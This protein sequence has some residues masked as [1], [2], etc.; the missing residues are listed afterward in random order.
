MKPVDAIEFALRLNNKRMNASK[1]LDMVKDLVNEDS[2]DA[3]HLIATAKS[4]TSRFIV[5]D[6]AI[7][8]QP[9]R[10]ANRVGFFRARLMGVRDALKLTPFIGSSTLGVELALVYAFAVRKADALPLIVNENDGLWPILDELASEF[11]PLKQ[12]LVGGLKEA[13]FMVRA[14]VQTELLLM[15]SVRLTPLEYVQEMR[16]LLTGQS[17]MWQFCLPWSVGELMTRLLGDDVKEVFDPAADSSVLPVLLSLRDVARADAVFMNRFSEF[18]TT[19]QARI[20]GVPFKSFLR[21]VSSIPSTRKYAHCISAPPFGGKISAEGGSRSVFAVA[22]EQVI[23][24]LAPGGQAAIL[25]PESMVFGHSGRAIRERL[26]KEGLLRT[27]I[28]LPASLFL[29]YAGVK[30]SILVLHSAASPGEVVFIDA[31]PYTSLGAKRSMTLDVDRL[32]GH[33]ASRNEELPIVHMDS[34]TLIRDENIDLSVARWLALAV[35]VDGRS[36]SP[37]SI[38][39]LGAL[40]IGELGRI[41]E[42]EDLPYFQVS[43]LASG[44]ADLI[45]TADHGRKDRPASAR[46]A[47]VLDAPALLVARVGGTLKPTLFDPS[48]GP[49]ALG[50]NVLA[51]RVKEELVDPRYLAVELRSGTVQEQVESYARGIAVPSL[52]KAD[53]LRLLIRVPDRPQ[54]VRIVE[55]QLDLGVFLD[56]VKTS[57]EPLGGD[58]EHFTRLLIKNAGSIGPS[59]MGKV[60]ND[61]MTHEIALAVRANASVTDENMRMIRHQ[62]NNRLG[63]LT[64]GIGSIRR[65]ILG[66]MDSGLI[67]QDMPIAPSLLGEE[68]RPPKVTETIEQLLANAGQ[69]SL[70]LDA[71]TRTIQNKGPELQE[72]EL[73]EFF[74][75]HIAPLYAAD[76][77]FDLHIHVVEGT[78]TTVNA[79]PFLLQQVVTNI[80]D[81]AVKHGFSD[82]QRRYNVYVGL[83]DQSVLIANDGAP[84]TISLQEMIIRGS[85]AGENAGTGFGMYMVNT[86]MSSMRGRLGQHMNPEYHFGQNGAYPQASAIT[87]GVTLR[88]L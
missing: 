17:E 83:S 30:T 48:S 71:L 75:E 22:L 72:V 53:L 1:I 37:E 86:L 65:F 15:A 49:I 36:A 50:S 21:E 74:N 59:G 78:N 3:N 13:W 38:M 81:N 23:D 11:P 8:L 32:M 61:W 69:L 46:N 25:V 68:R 43:E 12:E 63:W 79:D 73:S 27:V 33:L 67:P 40:V 31:A 39:P 64:G 66:L 76:N 20:L 7:E 85:S 88:F 52:A 62:L 26:V 44:P 35:K 70:L 45:R 2:V 19:L 57:G 47:R 77:R 18:F 10:A 56:R 5:K 82:P 87:F 14:R 34:E 24:R 58:M 60:L 4:D 6:G 80:I 54:Q 41:G 84:P 16:T 42:S 29:P 28:S 9:H 51:F 55:E